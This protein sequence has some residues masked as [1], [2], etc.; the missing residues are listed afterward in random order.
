MEDYRDQQILS[1]TQT[2]KVRDVSSFPFQITEAFS[3]DGQMLLLN[4]Y[5]TGANSATTTSTRS[6]PTAPRLRLIGQGTGI[7]FSFDGKWVLALDPLNLQH[8]ES[9]SHRSG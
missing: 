5:V 2:G 3:P 7:G 9:D 4:T 1:E 6:G 8:T